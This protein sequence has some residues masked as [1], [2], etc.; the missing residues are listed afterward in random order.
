MKRSRVKCADRRSSTKILCAS[1]DH[2]KVLDKEIQHGGCVCITFL[3]K[4]GTFSGQIWERGLFTTEHP[5]CSSQQTQLIAYNR[6]CWKSIRTTKSSPVPYIPKMLSDT[7]MRNHFKE[8][9]KE[10]RVNTSIWINCMRN[11]LQHVHDDINN[12]TMAVLYS[13]Y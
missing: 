7:F 10:H 12:H 3:N 4:T 5:S 2:G 1:H 6:L 8:E 9:F 13:D 11:I